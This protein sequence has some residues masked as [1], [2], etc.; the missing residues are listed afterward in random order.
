MILFLQELLSNL[1][2]FSNDTTDSS[3]STNISHFYFKIQAKSWKWFDQVDIGGDSL[4]LLCIIAGPLGVI[5][6][7]F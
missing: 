6:L 4:S 2:Y 3:S 1:L 7:F 5:L